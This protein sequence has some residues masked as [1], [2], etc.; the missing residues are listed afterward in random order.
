MNMNYAVSVKG[1]NGNEEYVALFENEYDARN[2]ASSKGGAGDSPSAA[3]VYTVIHAEV[4]I[5]H[6]IAPEKRWER[7]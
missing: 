2:Y 3:S 7:V 4:D 1:E 6:K 5:G